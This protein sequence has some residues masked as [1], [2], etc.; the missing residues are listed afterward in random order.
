MPK[1]IKPPKLME[2]DKIIP[3][4]VATDTSAKTTKS[5]REAKLKEVLHNMRLGLSKGK[6]SEQDI[7]LSVSGAEQMI[8]DFEELGKRILVEHGYS[9]N[10]K[11]CI[12]IDHET[13]PEISYYAY[14]MLSCIEQTRHWM[15]QHALH[16]DAI[17]ALIKQNIH[18]DICDHLNDMSLTMKAAV[19]EA[20]NAMG[21][22]VYIKNSEI[23]ENYLRGA[24]ILNG[25]KEGGYAT[26]RLYKGKREVTHNKILTYAKYLAG[27][28]VPGHQIVSKTVKEMNK[29][30]TKITANTVRSILV[31]KQFRK[32]RRRK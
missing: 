25:G 32:L 5:E 23:E 8:Q 1:K 17:G 20:V 30:G 21:K 12:G 6:G 26:G 9:D 27:K 7:T 22:F 10:W 4:Q 3:M 16:A 15:Q 2:F 31:Q 19:R 14:E 13:M 28:G 11:D 18:H 29:S 24:K